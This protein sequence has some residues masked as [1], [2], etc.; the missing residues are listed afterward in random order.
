[1]ENLSNDREAL[2]KMIIMWALREDLEGDGAKIS[3]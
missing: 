2:E 3:I 1:M